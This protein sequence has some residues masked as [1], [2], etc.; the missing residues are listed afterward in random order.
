MVQQLCRSEQDSGVLD[1]G[2]S[3]FPHG[4]LVRTELERACPHGAGETVRDIVSTRS[5]CLK[6]QEALQS[7]VTFLVSTETREGESTL[8]EIIMQ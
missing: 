2:G 5:I 8:E 6:D 3:R 7:E 1:V 4:F